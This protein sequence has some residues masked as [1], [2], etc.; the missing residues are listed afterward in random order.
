MSV[1]AFTSAGH[2]NNTFG[3]GIFDNQPSKWAPVG[4]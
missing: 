4:W 3:Q 1:P 2:G